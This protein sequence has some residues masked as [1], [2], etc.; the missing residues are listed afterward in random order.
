MWV[1]VVVVCVVWVIVSGV[2]CV[3]VL[4]GCCGGGGNAASAGAA[5]DR[6]VCFVAAMVLWMFGVY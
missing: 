6:R 1:I 2:M 5:D 3:D 4:W